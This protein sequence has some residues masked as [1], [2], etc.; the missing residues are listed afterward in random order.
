MRHLLRPFGIHGRQH[1]NELVT[2]QARQRVYTTQ[3]VHHTVRYLHQQTV[4]HTVPQGVI[5][6]FEVIQVEKH[7]RQAFA[8]ALRQTQRKL[9]ALLNLAPVGQTGELVKMR[10]PFYLRLGA[11]FLGDVT[12]NGQK[13]IDVVK[14]HRLG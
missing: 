10:Q 3:D 4:T 11:L 2:S 5:D 6:V 9:K 1:Q 13:A 12:G 14:L 8:A 7:H